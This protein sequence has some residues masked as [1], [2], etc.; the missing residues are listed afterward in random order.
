ML[1]AAL[2]L[3]VALACD[4]WDLSHRSEQMMKW[5]GM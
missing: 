1:G 4:A 3:G 2:V 5:M